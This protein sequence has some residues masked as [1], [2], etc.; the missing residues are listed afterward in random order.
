MTDSPSSGSRSP[1][2]TS[3]ALYAVAQV[4]KSLI[5]AGFEIFRTRG[6]EIVLA[7]RPR[8]NLILDSG[9]R[10]RAGAS[11]EVRMVVRAQR[12]DFPN[13]EDAHL[14]QRARSIGARAVAA[15]FAETDASATRVADPGD[16]S[17]TLD[18]FYEVTFA[19]AAESVADAVTELRFVLS[20]EK[21]A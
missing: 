1:P 15:G 3:P 18:T 10:L 9:V 21:R 8:E 5:E 17:R 7:E 4:K 6:D 20:L 14:F 19:K 12:A 16:P 13:D 11:L 2:A